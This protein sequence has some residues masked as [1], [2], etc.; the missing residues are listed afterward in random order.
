MHMFRIP[1][2]IVFY[3]QDQ[4]WIAH[5]LEMDLI[6]DGASREQALEQLRR[7]V[8]IQVE[9]SLDNQNVANLFQPADARYFEMFAAG[10]DVAAGT[11]EFP[12]ISVNGIRIDDFAARE[13]RPAEQPL[14]SG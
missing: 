8:S 9:T 7:A 1:L 5:C 12:A 2:R 4:R 14:A 10:E 6:G 3:R 11:L 13:Y